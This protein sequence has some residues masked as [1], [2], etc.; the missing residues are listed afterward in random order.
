MSF[1]VM[2]DANLQSFKQTSGINAKDANQLFEIYV[3]HLFARKNRF[4]NCLSEYTRFDSSNVGGESDSGID[5]IFI[6]I[7]GSFVYNKQDVD[8]IVKNNNSI[9]VEFIFIQSKN[10]TSIDSS[11]LSKFFSGIKNFLAD[12]QTDIVNGKINEWLELKKYIY[13]PEFL[14]LFTSQPSVLAI[15]VYKGKDLE[16]SHIYSKISEFKQD[17]KLM[18]CSL[19]P[20]VKIIDGEKLFHLIKE[21]DNNYEATIRYYDA[22]EL[23]ESD[24]VKSS[25]VL[26]CNAESLIKLISDESNGQLRKEMFADN[27]RDYQGETAV[28]REIYDTILNN[29]SKFCLLN[30]GITIV[31]KSCLSMNRQITLIN[32]QIVNGCQTSTSIYKAKLS[33]AKLD[34][35]DL[36]VKVIATDDSVVTNSIIKGTNRQNVVYTESF[37]IT[38]EFHKNFEEYVKNVQSN[39]K[40]SE[41]IYYERRA[42]QFL[43]DSNIS[44]SQK[45]GLASL[46][47]SFV[48]IF[49]VEP[50]L[51]FEHEIDLL[52]KFDGQIFNDSDSFKPYFASALLFLTIDKTFKD[53]YDIYRYYSKYRYQLMAI[54]CHLISGRVPSMSNVQ[55]I[56][57][58]CDKVIETIYSPNKFELVLKN[59]ID[60]FD[61]IKNKWIEERG[62]KFVHAI[63]DNRI[64]DQFMFSCLGFPYEKLNAAEKE[65]AVFVGIVTTVKKDR[66]GLRYC[67]IKADP[68][69][70]F[71]HEDNSPGTLFSSLSGKEVKY[72]IISTGRYNNPKGKIIKVLPRSNVIKE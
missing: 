28:N 19:E 70:V 42:N 55:K 34:L 29:P 14:S 66:N 24:N 57:S 31:C 35:V 15:Y 60:R 8:F 46:T 23:K 61:E 44:S 9:S 69:D 49:L 72:K 27:V 11:E 30:N 54:I 67:Y 45:F 18:D 53:K 22:F 52:E 21:I 33:G 20:L 48:S 17:I 1:S 4:F 13:A 38:R 32:P 40:P 12:K 64:F 65:D 36:I 47:Q 26:L 41:K 10:K 51:G 2:I 71:V 68:V 6:R 63:K 5:G 43:G 37:E 62:P 50:H 56:D 59:A 7:N 16:D 58:Y 3:N 25:L 39:L